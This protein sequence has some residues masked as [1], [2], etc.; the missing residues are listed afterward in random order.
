MHSTVESNVQVKIYEMAEEIRVRSEMQIKKEPMKKGNARDTLSSLITDTDL[1]LF[2][3]IFL[4][5]PTH[6]TSGQVVHIHIP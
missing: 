3:L 1:I 2:I 4:S 6:L 5:N